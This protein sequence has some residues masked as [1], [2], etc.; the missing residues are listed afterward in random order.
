MNGDKRRPATPSGDTEYSRAARLIMDRILLNGLVFFGRHGCH[1][2][3]KEL[4][5]KFVVDI[6]LEC[7]LRDAGRSDQ[8]DDTLDYVAMYNAARDILEGEPV[9]L[10]ETLAQRIAD[11]ALQ[12]GRV[13]SAWVR[14]RKPHIALPG[15]LDF[16]GVEITRGGDEAA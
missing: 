6:E 12:D 5:Q 15:A 3:E 1:Q 10:L 8:L 4:G 11:F 16:I 7:D 14:V 13:T 9:Q 2:A